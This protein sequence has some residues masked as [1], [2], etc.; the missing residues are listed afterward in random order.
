MG[1][2]SGG[3]WDGDID[4]NGDNGLVGDIGWDGGQQLVQPLFDK[5]SSVWDGWRDGCAGPHNTL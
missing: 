4:W 5:D 3:G 2:D 1:L